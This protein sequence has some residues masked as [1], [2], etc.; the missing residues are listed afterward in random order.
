MKPF[1]QEFKIS[2]LFAI[3]IASQDFNMIL[4]D[5]NVCHFTL[6]YPILYAIPCLIFKWPIRL[7]ASRVIFQMSCLFVHLS[8]TFW[9]HSCMV[10]YLILSLQVYLF[11]CPGRAK[12]YPR[13]G[14]FL[15]SYV[16]D[17]SNLYVCPSTR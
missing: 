17:N 11:C 2:W 8:V 16:Y 3:H 5:F 15:S 4:I 13:S 12:H 1:I 10:F 9:H 7:F 14:Y 6:F